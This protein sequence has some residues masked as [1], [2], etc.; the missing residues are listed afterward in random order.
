MGTNPIPYG[1]NGK[2]LPGSGEAETAPSNLAGTKSPLDEF[3]DE[4]KE[5]GRSNLQYLHQSR[6]ILQ[7]PGIIHKASPN[8]IQGWR[9]P[10]TFAVQTIAVVALLISG[11]QFT[12]THIPGSPIATDKQP[13]TATEVAL[14]KNQDL[15]SQVGSYDPNRMV[16][17][18][19]RNGSRS[20]SR[21]EAIAVLQEEAV[22]LRSVVKIEKDVQS[23]VNWLWT[24][25][26]PIFIGLALVWSS[27]FF[28][29]G[30][31]KKFGNT[32]YAAIADRCYLYIS[33]ARTF[34]A[35]ILLNIMLLANRWHAAGNDDDM[36]WEVFLGALV[37]G[38]IAAFVARR[39]M[40][41]DLSAVLNLP[42]SGKRVKDISSQ[43][44]LSGIKALFL[45]FVCQYALGFVIGYAAPKVLKYFA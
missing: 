6:L 11:V 16:T 30:I 39:R 5:R 38:L 42:D 35:S 45:V 36:V 13:L 27:S 3:L 10:M 40:S 34:W 12:A 14:Q 31:L 32:G 9:S 8:S 22:K 2:P 19:Y 28:K 43:I 29:G 17:L 33:S 1:P 41:Q 37:L 20:Y 18:L 21:D 25:L 23:L 24:Y 15:V 44:G 7:N 26:Q 4:W